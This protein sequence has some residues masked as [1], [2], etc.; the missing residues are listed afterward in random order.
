[1]G[2]NARRRKAERSQGDDG[3]RLLSIE[4][5]EGRVHGICGQAV[6]SKKVRVFGFF[7][8]MICVHADETKAS[9]AT[10]EADSEEAAA[11]RAEVDVIVRQTERECRHREGS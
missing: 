8:V 9:F 4:A 10:F 11:I 6:Y 2:R 1:M 3:M 5:A 7:P